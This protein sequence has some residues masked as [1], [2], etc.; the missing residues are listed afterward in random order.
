M[1]D[2]SSAVSLNLKPGWASA[3][4]KLKCRYSTDWTATK[5]SSTSSTRTSTRRSKKRT[6]TRT[7]F[8]SVSTEWSWIRKSDR[9]RACAVARVATE[10][11]HNLHHRIR[12]S[13]SKSS[14][15]H[16]SSPFFK[17]RNI[18]V[19]QVRPSRQTI[20]TYLSRKYSRLS[21]MSLMKTT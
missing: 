8:H 11:R 17:C 20:A 6:D 5:I 2:S 19:R 1:A 9:F 7:C 16:N 13:H 15:H 21:A 12:L 14:Q 4:R 3:T 18:L 10:N